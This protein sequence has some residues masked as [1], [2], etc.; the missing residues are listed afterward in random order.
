MIIFPLYYNL[1]YFPCRQI[2]P[3]DDFWLFHFT[4]SFILDKNF[5]LEHHT[6]QMPQE[7]MGFNRAHMLFMKVCEDKDNESVKEQVGSIPKG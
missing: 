1:S 2:S 4:F 3:S 6:G 7:V 5:S